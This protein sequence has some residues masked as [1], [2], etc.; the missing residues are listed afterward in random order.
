MESAGVIAE[1]AKWMPASSEY[2]NAKQT[3]AAMIRIMRMNSMNGKPIRTS[4]AL[5]A[6]SLNNVLWMYAIG[7]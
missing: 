1:V 7:H 5:S 2:A 3:A 4:N 6:D